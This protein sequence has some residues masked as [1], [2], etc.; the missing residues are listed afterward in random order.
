MDLSVYYEVVGYLASVLVAVSLMM[1]SVIKLR[2][3]NMAGACTFIIYG[4]LIGS[5]PVALL[6]TLIV[7]INLYYLY[8]IFRAKEY[9]TILEEDPNSE[10]LKHFLKFYKKEI[11]KYNPG[12]EYVPSPDQHIY[13]MLR[14]LIP[15][16]LCI[17]ELRKDGVAEIQLDFVIPG[18]RDFKTGKFIYYDKRK[19]FTDNGI[20]KVV[21]RT[22]NDRH[23]H[24]L[25]KMG[26]VK[27]GQSH[28]AEWYTLDF[29]V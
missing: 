5:M 13:F 24:Y 4:F 1:S 29:S 7:A 26:F 8:H 16:G 9:F 28:E 17:V 15:A 20:K 2:I 27:T 18:Y 19:L 11:E 23:K 25:Q 10:Y 6:N 22:D 3:I 21:T 12:F 14:N